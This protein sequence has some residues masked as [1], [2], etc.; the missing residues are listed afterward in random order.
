MSLQEAIDTLTMLDAAAGEA[1]QDE[2]NELEEE[3]AQ[4]EQDY[5]EKCEE[6]DEKEKEF[7]ILKDKMDDIRLLAEEALE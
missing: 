6:F 3:K 7:D 4:W 5:D 1:A 2:L